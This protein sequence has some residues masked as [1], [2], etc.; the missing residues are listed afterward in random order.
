MEAGEGMV[1]LVRVRTLIGNFSTVAIKE[2]AIRT[3]VAQ[4]LA[5][6]RIL[7]VLMVNRSKNRAP[8]QAAAK[9]RLAQGQQEVQAIRKCLLWTA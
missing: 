2:Q 5:R 4:L 8:R 6:L 7:A 3:Q 1:L 9:I